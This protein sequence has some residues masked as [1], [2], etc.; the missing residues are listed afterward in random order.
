M[1][2]LLHN[3]RKLN[4]FKVVE[5][6]QSKVKVAQKVLTDDLKSSKILNLGH[7]KMGEKGDEVFFVKSSLRLRNFFL[8][9]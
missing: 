9:H 1:G 6:P 5:V 2:A 3:Q 8:K 7:V 4:S